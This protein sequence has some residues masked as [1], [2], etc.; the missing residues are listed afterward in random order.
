MREK[1]FFLF[2][3]IF[4]NL[5]YSQKCTDFKIGEFCQADEDGFYCKIIRTNETQTLIFDEKLGG[6]LVK[7][8]YTIKWIDE[9]SYILKFDFTKMDWNQDYQDINDSGGIL[10][11]MF[12]AENDCYYFTDTLWYLGDGPVKVLRKICFCESL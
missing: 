7:N 6:T 2:F 4:G 12:K 11:E 5:S 9:C 1:L 10:C 8:Y 3:L